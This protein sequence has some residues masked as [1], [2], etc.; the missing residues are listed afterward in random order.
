MRIFYVFLLIVFPGL[1]MAQNV[2][3]SGYIRDMETGEDLIG[4][5]I[6]VAELKKGASSNTYGYYS[7]SIKEG[8]Y[9]LHV[10]YIGYQSQEIPI[11]LNENTKLNIVLTPAENLTQEV[12]VRAEKTDRNITS[13]E[14]GTVKMPVKQIKAL[15]VLFGEVDILKTIQ[16]LPGVQSANEGSTGFY[17]RGGGPDQNLI[18]LDGANVYNSAH[19]FGFFSVFN[20]DA[21]KDVKL[22]KGGMPA[23]YGGR[24]SSVLDI[25]M[26]EGNMKEYAAQGGIGLISSRLTV[27]GP[28]KKDTSSFIVSGRRTYIDILAKPFI[29]DTSMFAG[30]GYYFYDLN[31]KI[32]YRLS[33]K[34][35]VFLSGYF[36]RDVFTFKNSE[37][38]IDMEIPWGNAT[39]S[40]RWN[41]LFSDKLF[42]NTTAIFSD[43]QF[44]INIKQN[45][46]RLKLFS[47]ITDYSLITDFNYFPNINHKMNF[48]A[49]Y[50]YHIFVP[51]S[52]STKSDE[53]VFEV[54]DKLR[55]YAHD[56][57]W[58]VS[59]EFSLNHRIK[60]NAGLRASFFQQVGPFTRYLKDED[61][62]FSDTINYTKGDDVTHFFNVE[63]RL[64][65][66]FQVNENSSV[67]ASYT[68]NYQ[69]IHMASLS[70]ITM[71]TDLWVPSSDVVKPQF[72]VQYSLGYF[73]NFRN[74]LFE[75]SAEI[76]YK[77]LDHQIE[78]KPNSTV[79]DN[80]GD[81]ADNNFTFGEGQS[82]GL[83]LF[84]KKNYGKT[85]GWIGYTLSKTTR[86]FEQINN[87]EV[88]SAKYDR[89]HDLSLIVT[90]ELSDRWSVSA[91][92]V[93]AT[94]SAFTPTIA[95]YLM[96]NATFIT[97]FGKYNSYRMKNYHR[98]DLS[99]TY[100]LKKR[101]HFSSSLNFSIYN[102]YN[103]HNPYFIYFDYE[104]EITSGVFMT[105]AKQITVFPI[106]PSISWNFE[107]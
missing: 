13:T 54:G 66:R 15:P 43:Y 91:V 2:T 76:Y 51:S 79:G 38:D 8:S 63:P 102:I 90:H 16:L 62:N 18:L 103:R 30:S 106:L 42:V 57:S 85:T 49:H 59:D 86:Q 32:N 28:L 84:V 22:I 82:Y 98:L 50:I 74:N 12:E 87:G 21:I 99:A 7:I 81:N 105:F 23:N 4:A 11:D 17:V 71:P 3:V 5:N 100:Q 35:R 14:M 1:L 27:E 55:Q 72:G 46:Y 97:E 89:R 88:F 75:T 69:Y 70:A 101:K 61:G 107:F 58:Y 41:H 34:D 29:S 64:S 94:G 19:L 67:K 25:S 56:L 53:D 47:G 80:I 92:F 52:V 45:D 77:K 44:D 95:W 36:G 104:G 73:H 31:A 39:A 93:Y 26:K 37:S 65:V 48:G 78:Y 83:E 96:D 20:A 40:L 60:V 33:D 10:S 68:Q 24:L 9:T 6:V